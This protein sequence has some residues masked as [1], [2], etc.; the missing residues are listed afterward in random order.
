MYSETLAERKGTGWFRCGEEIGYFPNSVRRSQ[1]GGCYTLTFKLTFPFCDDTV[2]LAHCFPYT[3]TRLQRQ[4][5]ALEH[6]DPE[7]NV[8]QRTRLCATLA[9]NRV[10]LLTITNFTS[11][12]E[13][14]AKRRGVM[15]TARVHP[16]ET[17]ASWIMEG[18]LKFLVSSS[19]RAME[20]RDMYVFKIVPMLNPDGVINGNYRCSLAGVDLN[21]Q[22]K[23]PHPLKHRPIFCAKEVL[24]QLASTREVAMYCDFHGHSSKH[25]VFMYGCE[26]TGPKKHSEKVF[27][28]LMAEVCDVFSAN[29]CHFMM[30][31]DKESCGR[32]VV[33][34]ELNIVNSY[35]LEASFA[36]A[37]TGPSAG[38]HFNVSH[39]QA[40]GCKFLDA[41][42]LYGQSAADPTGGYVRQ[43]HQ[44]ICQTIASRPAVEPEPTTKKKPQKK[45]T[46]RKE[47]VPQRKPAA[48]RRR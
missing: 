38:I 2:Y 5:A 6:F 12:A 35:T 20:L 9:G 42:L 10:D 33:F 41:L 44:D 24:K 19:P 21:R 15:L 30:K 28:L 27:P 23:T 11:C 26:A 1:D 36:G 37:D 45:R 25:N 17:G 39:Y 16:G 31:K 14:I 32:V 3:W 34:K 7:T 47:R 13:A 48:S 43:L 4:L 46:T 18:L 40:M 8:L 22:W 29:D